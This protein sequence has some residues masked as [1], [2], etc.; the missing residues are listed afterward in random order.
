MTAAIYCRLS[1]EDEEKQSESESIQ[2]QKSMLIKYALDKGWDIYNIYCDEDY[3]ALT[4]NAR[5]FDSLSRMQRRGGSTLC[6]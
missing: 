2:N 4:G 3:S 5:P 1:R 6:W